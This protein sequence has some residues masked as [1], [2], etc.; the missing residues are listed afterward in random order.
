M[1][2]FVLPSSHVMLWVL[3]DLWLVPRMEVAVAHAVRNHCF[4]TPLSR[5]CCSVKVFMQF[6]DHTRDNLQCF[7][8]QMN[9]KTTNIGRLN[10]VVSLT[11]VKSWSPISSCTVII[12]R[13]FSC[14]FT[15]QRINP[16]QKLTIWTLFS[17]Q[18][19]F[20]FIAAPVSLFIL[21]FYCSCKSA[22][23]LKSAIH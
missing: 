19:Q 4:H 9:L 3:C 11:L 14:V 13:T 5:C 21:F 20:M 18:P 8:V 7:A 22:V 23:S 1:C 12:C 15:D 2:E 6:A 16:W 17:L 10:Y